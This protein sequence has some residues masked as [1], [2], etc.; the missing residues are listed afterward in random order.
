MLTRQRTYLSPLLPVSVT[1]AQA[2]LF[3]KLE[4]TLEVNQMIVNL[5]LLFTFSKFSA[6][7]LPRL[8]VPTGDKQSFSNFS[9]PFSQVVKILGK[10][11]DAS[12]NYIRSFASF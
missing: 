1:K 4:R 12:W 9:M 7:L 3:S 8:S 5:I 6:V 11:T 10:T 2:V